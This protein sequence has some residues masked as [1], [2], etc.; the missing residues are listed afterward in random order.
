MLYEES[1]GTLFAG[2][3]FTQLG[4]GPALTEGDIV[5]PAI[6][7]EDVF[8]AS[9]LSASMPTTIEQLAGLAPTTMALMHGS[10][11][12]GDCA[13]ALSALAADSRRRIAASARS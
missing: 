9:S 13:V 3:L 7:A 8:H 2:D 6:R 12:T 1:S 4:D 5:D 10:S 11:F